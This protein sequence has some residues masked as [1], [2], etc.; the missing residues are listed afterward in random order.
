MRPGHGPIRISEHVIPDT[1]CHVSR[2][3][4]RGKKDSAPSKD[5]LYPLVFFL[6]LPSVIPAPP[7]SIKGRAGHPTNGMDYFS[8][9]NT[10]PSSNQA[11]GV[12]STFPS[13][14][15]DLSLSRLY[16]LLQTFFGTNTTSGSKLDVRTFCPNQYKPCVL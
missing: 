3:G 14:T 10:Q 15:W 1:V 16:P 4:T 13:E 9:H 2:A 7:W 11:L 8:T 12:L 5:L 6:F